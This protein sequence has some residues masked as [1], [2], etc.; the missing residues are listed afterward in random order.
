MNKQYAGHAK[1]V[2]FGIWSFLRQFMYTKMIIV[3]DADVDIR[4]WKEVVWALTTRVDAG[5]RHADRAG[6][7]DRLS[8]LRLARGG[9]R[10][11]DRHRRHEQVARGNGARMGPPHCDGSGG[12]LRA[13]KRSGSRSAV[14]VIAHRRVGC[15]AASRGAQQAFDLAQHQR[16]RRGR[17]ALLIAKRKLA[18]ERVVD[19]QMRVSRQPAAPLERRNSPANASSWRGVIGRPDR[20]Y[21]NA[22]RQCSDSFSSRTGIPQVRQPAQ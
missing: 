2:M 17:R 21:S 9:A 5:A 10:R 22:S 20:R 4:D 6:H 13:S 18:Q 7:A 14:T 15:G 11:Q 3:T 19:Q 8:G 12:Q 16:Q 1:R